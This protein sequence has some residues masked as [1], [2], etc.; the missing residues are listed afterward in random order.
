[1]TIEHPHG[2][3]EVPLADWIE[4]GPGP[5]DLLR[6]TAAH[7]R[8]TGERLPLSVIPLPFRNSRVS[9]ALVRLGVLQTPWP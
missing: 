7:D 3:V 6:P 1:M 9:R 4:R 8:Q 2:P 5:R